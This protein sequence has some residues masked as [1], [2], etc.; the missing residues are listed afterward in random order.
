MALHLDP[1]AA[2]HEGTAPPITHPAHCCAPAHRQRARHFLGYLFHC[3]IDV[4]RALES[5]LLFNN[6]F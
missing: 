4:E 5:Q 1:A 2:L 3:Y 6:A